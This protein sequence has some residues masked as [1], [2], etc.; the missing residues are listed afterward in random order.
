MNV[1]CTSKLQRF[2]LAL[3]F[4]VT[5][6]ITA[7]SVLAQKFDAT[8][9]IFP[10]RQD[11]QFFSYTS[12]PQQLS[13]PTPA[14]PV[15]IAK[16]NL[17][18]QHKK[19]ANQ[20]LVDQVV[21]PFS[22]VGSFTPNSLQ[23]ISA[24]NAWTTDFKDAKSDR[25]PAHRTPTPLDLQL[26]ELAREEPI[27]IESLGPSVLI[28]RNR[29]TSIT[30]IEVAP[31]NPLIGSSPVIATIEEDYM[32]Y[33]LSA[34][35]LENW[36]TYPIG[37]H[38]FNAEDRVTKEQTASL[39]DAFDLA[40]ALSKSSDPVELNGIAKATLG[41]AP[42]AVKSPSSPSDLAMPCES[43]PAPAKSQSSQLGEVANT[44]ST[45]QPQEEASA[46]TS[47]KALAILTRPQSLSLSPAPENMSDSASHES[48]RRE[49]V[50]EVGKTTKTGPTDVALEVLMENLPTMA[51]FR[52]KVDVKNIGSIAGRL[53]GS[54]T[55][56]VNL[57]I[58]KRAAQ[59]ALN[60]PVPEQ[61]SRIGARL[62]SR[63]NV[64]ESGRIEENPARRFIPIE[65]LDGV[66]C[67][68]GV[69][70]AVADAKRENKAR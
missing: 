28:P 61:P 34:R 51:A 25:T 55:G 40:M 57:W 43:P 52:S 26:Q 62:L 19:T 11:E 69:T 23:G 21:E 18:R 35:D 63:A 42:S 22:S 46:V 1:Q 6:A 33:D 17:L 58:G 68:G 29:P 48:T 49:T 15:L 10:L 38:P 4:T 39:W 12:R 32:P 37:P 7:P 5:T 30:R 50:E 66:D 2:N 41:L 45:P 59:I 14:P 20:V 13:R 64:L 56:S 53:I 3:I 24:Q 16:A 36:N 31:I 54:Y 67:G 9:D 47:D 44:K 27:D 8:I 60:W 70:I 65:R